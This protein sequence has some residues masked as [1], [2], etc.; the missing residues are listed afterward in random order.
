MFTYELAR[1][2]RGGEVTATVRHPGVVRTAFGAEDQAT[3]F[4][5]DDEPAFG[6]LD[7]RWGQADFASIPPGAI[8]CF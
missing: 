5:L 3:Y 1:R 8:T 2:L 4:R 6:R 7:R